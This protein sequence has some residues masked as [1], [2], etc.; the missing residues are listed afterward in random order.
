MLFSVPNASFIDI[1][2]GTSTI[3]L[4]TLAKGESEIARRTAKDL[5]TTS[6]EQGFTICGFCQ[7]NGQDGQVIESKYKMFPAE[8]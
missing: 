7:K 8:D 3:T 1:K 6:G 4:N 5:T 2:I